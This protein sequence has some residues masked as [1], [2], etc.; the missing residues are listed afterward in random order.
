MKRGDETHS[1]TGFGDTMQTDPLKGPE[2]SFCRSAT[3]ISLGS[4]CRGRR[5]EHWTRGRE[6]RPALA[7][8]PQGLE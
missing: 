6:R 5:V 7:H 1:L 8:E 3:R 2:A 4:P